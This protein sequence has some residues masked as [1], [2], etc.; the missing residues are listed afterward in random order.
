MMFFPTPGFPWCPA[1]A[2]IKGNESKP[3]TFFSMLTMGENW[4]TEQVPTGKKY[5]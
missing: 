3:L 1:A 4:D 5:I 2:Y